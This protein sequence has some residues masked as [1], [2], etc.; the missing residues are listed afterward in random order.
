M[1][2][3]IKEILK[4][5]KR[6]SDIDDYVD[7]IGTE[8]KPLLDYITNLQ[9]SQETLI[10]NDNEIITNLQE[11]NNILKEN[12]E[13]NDKV[14]DKAKWNEMLYKSRIDKAIEYIHNDQL[15]FRLSSKKQIE[16][17]FDDFYKDILDILKG[18]DK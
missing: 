14:V 10:K 12:A 7:F 13:H 5:I 18:E 11:E 2:D 9:K 15:V 8:F 17:W 1:K 6:V 16:D 3:E 4:K